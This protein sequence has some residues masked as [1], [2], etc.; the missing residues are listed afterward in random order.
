MPLFGIF[1]SRLIEQGTT[2]FAGISPMEIDFYYEDFRT[3]LFTAAKTNM[4]VR[5]PIDVMYVV[6]I[7]KIS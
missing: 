5:W 7:I 3:V 1:M 6:G 2:A 4:F